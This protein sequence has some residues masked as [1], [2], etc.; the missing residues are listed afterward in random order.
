MWEK[1]TTLSDTVDENF[2]S[3]FQ[4]IDQLRKD[5]LKEQKRTTYTLA[6]HDNLRKEFDTRTAIIETQMT[7][8]EA[9]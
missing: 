1:I 8:N 3:C 2:K 6:E 5:F 9:R 7:T 4:S